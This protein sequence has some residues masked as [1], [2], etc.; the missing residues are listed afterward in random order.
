[1]SGNFLKTLNSILSNL[2][3]KINKYKGRNC[4]TVSTSSFTL[5]YESVVVARFCHFRK[6]CDSFLITGRRNQPE[7]A[8]GCI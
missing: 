4:T 2:G 1:M 3:G 8:E 7:S 6:Q 5:Q